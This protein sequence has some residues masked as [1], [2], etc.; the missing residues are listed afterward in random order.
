MYKCIELLEHTDQNTL[1]NILYKCMLAGDCVCRTNHIAD[2]IIGTE[3]EM[4]K[5]YDPFVDRDYLY[6][7]CTAP[8]A[9]LVRE[10]VTRA[11]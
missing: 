6:S 11:A 2:A 5:D 8:K 3:R 4:E 10:A 1:N 7:V 9:P